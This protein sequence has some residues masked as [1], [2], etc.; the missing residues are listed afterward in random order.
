MTLTNRLDSFNT[1][2]VEKSTILRMGEYIFSLGGI[3]KN[4]ASPNFNL[5]NSIQFAKI[6]LEDSKEILGQFKELEPT[7]N[8][9]LASTK[10]LIETLKMSVENTYFQTVNDKTFAFIF[11]WVNDSNSGFLYIYQVELENN[12]ETNEPILKFTLKTVN[13]HY[14][15]NPTIKKYEDWFICFWIILK[16]NLINI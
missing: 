10:N 3:N 9:N 2:K 15:I 6:E 12:P 13:Q 5:N 16:F 7:E 11:N 4:S 14:L 1:L 8:S